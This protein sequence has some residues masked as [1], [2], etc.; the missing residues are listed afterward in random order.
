MGIS[1]QQRHYFCELIFQDP[2]LRSGTSSL[3]QEY[4]YLLTMYVTL[5]HWWISWSWMDILTP[6][7]FL[8]ILNILDSVLKI[9]WDSWSPFLESWISSK[10]KEVFQTWDRR[11]LCQS[12]TLMN[13]PEMNNYFEPIPFVNDFSVLG[14]ILE[15]FVVPDL[16]FWSQECPSKSRKLLY[17]LYSILVHFSQGHN[18]DF[19]NI[20]YGSGSFPMNLTQYLKN[21]GDD[22]SYIHYVVYFTERT[23]TLE[24]RCLLGFNQVPDWRFSV[25]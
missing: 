5:W 17:N 6:N 16:H 2:W 12:V 19:R 8:M 25:K 3:N 13:T 22:I 10:V 14:S 4:I 15:P 1:L 23:S 24:A 21:V 7:L 18:I 11:P 20:L 9:V